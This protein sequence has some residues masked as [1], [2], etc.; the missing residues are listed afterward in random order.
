MSC[1]CRRLHGTLHPN[2]NHTK[3]TIVP[4][5]IQAHDPC[6]CDIRFNHC[7]SRENILRFLVVGMVVL[8]L[9]ASAASRA[10]AGTWDCRARGR[11][12]GDCVPARRAGA[13]RWECRTCNRY[14][15]VLQ[16]VELVEL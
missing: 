2:S 6:N 15:S 16:V 13:G 12:L 1:N 5:L 4:S 7:I 11:Y 3:S 14:L 8:V 9:V 10:G